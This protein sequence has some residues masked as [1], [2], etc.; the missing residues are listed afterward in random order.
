[1]AVFARTEGITPS[2]IQFSDREEAIQDLRFDASGVRWAELTPGARFD[3]SE[4]IP[5]RNVFRL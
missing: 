1:M 5:E 3:T 4:Q 2:S